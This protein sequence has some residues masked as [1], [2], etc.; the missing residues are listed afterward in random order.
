VTTHYMDEAEYCNRLALIDQGRIVLIGT[1]TEIKR[2]AIKGV[3]WLVECEPLGRG[4]D[5]IKRAMGV[6][7]AAVFGAALH[8]VA[9]PAKPAATEL[10]SYLA[11]QGVRVGRI[12][13]I[14]PSLED[15]FVAL[16]SR[17]LSAGEARQ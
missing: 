5:L 10:P 9:D 12:E 16:T 17:T 4:L 3:L 6:L 14:N 13:P 7:D 2:T 15:A 1:P 11:A 8:V